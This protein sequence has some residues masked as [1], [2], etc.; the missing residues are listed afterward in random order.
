M[1]KRINHVSD[2][3]PTSVL[4]LKLAARYINEG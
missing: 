2:Y 3:R 1:F 4:M